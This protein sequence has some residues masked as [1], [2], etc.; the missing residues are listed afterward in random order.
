MSLKILCD[1]R[2]IS[3]PQTFVSMSTKY[4]Q[5]KAL[6]AIEIFSGEQMRGPRKM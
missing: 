4:F 1:L 5:D 2:Y 3:F 6:N